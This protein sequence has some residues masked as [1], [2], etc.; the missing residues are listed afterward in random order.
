MRT[1]LI[2]L[3]ALSLSWGTASAQH[4]SPE[5]RDPGAKY[6]IDTCRDFGYAVILFLSGLMSLPSDCYE[7]SQIDGAT[8]WQTFR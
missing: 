4:Y 6:P 2:L 7:S 3:S 5:V 8:A 1:F